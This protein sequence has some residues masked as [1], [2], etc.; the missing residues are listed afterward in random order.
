MSST[1]KQ[2][3]TILCI[4]A[5]FVASVPVGAF[6]WVDNRPT[7]DSCCAEQPGGEPAGE[8]S[9]GGQP[10]DDSCCPSGCHDCFLPCC[11]GLLSLSASPVSFV[12]DR[13]SQ[14]A[15]FADDEEFPS[16]HPRVVYHPPRR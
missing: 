3:S 10:L 14:C 2:F 16:A 6:D 15:T 11:N 7:D 12:V 9:D 1:F 13:S 4:V 5:L 8:R